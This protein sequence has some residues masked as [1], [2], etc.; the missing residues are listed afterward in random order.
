MQAVNSI[1][2]SFAKRQF[3]AQEGR[4]FLWMPVAM[5]AGI[6][7]YFSLAAEPVAY[8][9]PAALLLSLPPLALLRR[10]KWRRIA[11]GIFFA[12][13]GLAA[14]QFRAHALAGPLLVKELRYRVVEGVVQLVDPA[15]GKDKIIL[16]QPVI[17]GLP[18][19]QTPRAIRVSVRAGGVPL[20]AGDRI[21][22]K[23][24]LY[25][26]SLPTRPG[27]YDFSRHFYFSGIGGSGYG[28]SAVEIVEPHKEQGMAL[29]VANLSHAMG[30]DM[31]AAMP[32]QAGAVAAAMTVGEIG[33]ISEAVRDT[34]R[35]SGLYHILSIS[36]LHLALASG[37]VFFNVRLLLS[38]FPALALRLPIKKIAALVALA[39]AFF[40]L[41]LAGYPIPAQR[42][43]IMVAFV[44]V[45]VLCDRTGVTLRTLAL[46]ALFI[47]LF[48]PDSLMG[49]SFQMSF[50]ATLAIVSLYER[51]GA[52]LSR[53]GARWWGRLLAYFLGILAT[54]LAA[55]LATAPFVLYHFNRFALLGLVSNLAVLPLATFVI[56]PGIVLSLLLMP[57]GLQAIGY[58][59]LAL[60]TQWMLG[61]AQWVTRFPGASLQLP[62]LSDSGLVLASAGLLMLCLLAGRIRLLG[63]VPLALGLATITGHIPA[64]VLVSADAKQVMVRLE[65]GEYTTLKGTGRAFSVEDWLRSEGKETLV[66]LKE[67]GLDCDDRLCTYVRNGHTLVMV[68][69]ADGDAILDEVCHRQ[70]DIM[71]AWRYLNAKRCPGP[72]MLIGRRELE[73]YG[74]H[75]LWLDAGMVRVEHAREPEKGSRL[76]QAVPPGSAYA[77]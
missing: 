40:Y 74:P 7:A 28:L 43:F 26:L 19:E 34:L 11:W 33:P 1:V 12:A 47:L 44:L 35:D 55:T 6:A 63:M 21:R 50:A 15:E 17:E 59:P 42:S 72:K 30:E 38:L 2:L 70:P 37:I 61:V 18:A 45:A 52:A 73:A 49:A 9:G 71:I 23:A 54:S 51:F 58:V 69:K 25:P 32:G 56:M 20:H 53:P 4:F 8:V 41:A 68:K 16:T 65:N 31:R 75:A 24:T 62:S 64:D 48:F 66:P 60:G 67:S 77:E 27:S 22:L 57:L 10:S 39:G 5:M 13:L 3:S 14:A 29:A 46:A 36:G 76:W